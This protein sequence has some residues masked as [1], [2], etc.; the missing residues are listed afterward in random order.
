MFECQVMQLQIQI[1]NSLELHLTI[2]CDEQRV[3]LPQFQVSLYTK[4]MQCASTAACG[5]LYSGA[6]I[7][8]TSCRNME[9][10]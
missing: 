8:W 10:V 5:V 7:S 1:F 3:A 4:G 9:Y 6:E 2:S